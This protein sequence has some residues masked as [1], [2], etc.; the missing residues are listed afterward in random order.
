MMDA[1]PGKPD[2]A[3]AAKKEKEL[4]EEHG[5]LELHP[6]ARCEASHPEYVDPNPKED[7]DNQPN[8]K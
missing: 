5:N 4:F 2:K 6:E 3:T 7:T 8:R 1:E